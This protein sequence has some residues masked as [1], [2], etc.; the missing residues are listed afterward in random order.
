MI[1]KTIKATTTTTDQGV[2]SALAAT[3]SVDRVGDRIIKGAFE[4]TIAAWQASQKQVPVHWDHEGAASSVIGSVDPNS[5][6]ETEDGLYVE[7]KLDLEDS[8]TARE[9][10]RSMK[11]NR[12]SLSFGYLATKE[13]KAK[14]GINELLEIDLFEV[15]IVPAPANPD[16]RLLSLKSVQ[17]KMAVTE[18]AE[19][20]SADKPFALMDGEEVMS[21]H[22]TEAEARQ[23][24]QEMMPKSLDIEAV[25]EFVKENFPDYQVT[26]IPEG[27]SEDPLRKRTYALALEASGG[28]PYARYEEPVPDPQPEPLD[29][30]A[31]RRKSDE[32]ALQIALG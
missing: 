27:K 17:T 26:K 18:D 19:R 20:C 1:H 32:L 3:Y 5:M 7:G 24:M 4:S 16:T 9:A 8:E 28:D 6:E 22:A 21:C 2:F 13:R 31:L 30:V 25:Q 23:A 11:D 14:D 29:E 10:W 15:S 12:V